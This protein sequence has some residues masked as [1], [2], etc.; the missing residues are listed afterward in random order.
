[1]WVTDVAGD[2]IIAA[3]TGSPGGGGVYDCITLDPCTNPARLDSDQYFQHAD[4]S[5]YVQCD[6]NDQCFVYSCASPLVWY[7]ERLICDW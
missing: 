2:P 7:Q 5:K 1:M 4:P 3:T 6:N